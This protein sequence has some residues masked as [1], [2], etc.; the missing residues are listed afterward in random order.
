MGPV[1]SNEGPWRGLVDTQVRMALRMDS[2]YLCHTEVSSMSL[3]GN[4]HWTT[5]VLD[6][7][8]P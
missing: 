5:S 7:C 4:P 6:V 1:C 8:A 2:E 3:Q